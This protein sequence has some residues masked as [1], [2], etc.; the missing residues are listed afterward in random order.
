MRVSSLKKVQKVS[1]SNYPRPTTPSLSLSLSLA[2]PKEIP[3]GVNIYSHDQTGAP[4][5]P[6]IFPNKTTTSPIFPR[7]NSLRSELPNHHR[8]NKLTVA[9]FPTA[10][11][12]TFSPHD[13]S[14]L[15]RRKRRAP[16]EGASGAGPAAAKVFLI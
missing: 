4:L 13:V 11:S 8:S 5:P 7:E 9:N 10:V 3:F 15:S 6:N 2:R 14:P 1:L 16:R 12:N